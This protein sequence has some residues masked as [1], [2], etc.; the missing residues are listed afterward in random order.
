MRIGIEHLGIRAA[1]SGDHRS[2]MTG[3]AEA[4]RT[5]TQ[6]NQIKDEQVR[7]NSRLDEIVGMLGKIAETQK[8]SADS[9]EERFENQFEHKLVEKEDAMAARVVELVAGMMRKEK[10]VLMEDE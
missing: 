1:L 2:I 9:L 5:Q 10:G 6:M 7:L 4:T 8:G 3:V